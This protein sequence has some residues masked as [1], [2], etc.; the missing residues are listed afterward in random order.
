MRGTTSTGAAPG[1]PDVAEPGPW[2]FPEPTS[3]TR[4]DNGLRVLG[5]D[6]PGQYVV[7]A[8]LV[9]PLPLHSE[10]RDIEGVA[11]LMASLLDEGTAQHTSEEFAALLERHGIAFS[12]GV[13][14]GALL[15][16]VDVPLRRLDVALELMADALGDPVFP[17]DEVRRLRTARL[18][19]LKQERASAPHRASRELIATLWAPHDR[20]S[21]PTAGDAVTVAA[22]TRDDVVRF[23]AERVGP[24]GASLVVAGALAGTDLESVVAATLGR[25]TAPSHTAPEP[26]RPPELAADAARVV[27]VDRPGSVQSEIA[28]GWSGPDRHAPGGWAPYPV[29]GY[30][31]G[32]SPGA[33]IDAVLRE[34]KGYTYGMRCGFRPRRAGGMIVTSGSVRAD[35]TVESLE[36]LSELLDPGQVE[37]TAE[38]VRGGVDF[39]AGTAPG[40]YATADS[41]GAEAISLLMDR[42]PLDFTTTT[43]EAMLDLTP[44]GLT[45]TYAA[46]APQRWCLVV[47]GD[48]SRYADDVRA[49]GLGDVT[50]VAN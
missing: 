30:L 27:L 32:G 47:V 34:D 9:V 13:N 23:H 3:D 35:V 36:I 10:P 25:W 14:D 48:A 17:E 24:A 15:V 21:R 37:F 5:Y 11:S 22:I 33:R 26:S 31:L 28:M 2:S 39:I 6:V 19:Q 4:L 8:S 7:T 41:I 38:E 12:A 16:D 18:A 20:A 44:K 45:A 49:L 50:I 42:V 29:I 1:R 43:R 46:L 40:R